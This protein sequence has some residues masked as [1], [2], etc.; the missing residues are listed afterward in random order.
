MRGSYI[1]TGCFLD[2]DTLLRAV[3]PIRQSPLV[4][5]IEAPHVTS[6]FRPKWV[7]R[8]LFGSQME[9]ALIGYGNDGN[10]EGVL[11]ELRQADAAVRDLFEQIPVPHITLAVSETGKPVD[12]KNLRFTPIQTIVLTGTYGGY[13]PNGR[14]Q[15]TP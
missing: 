14:V 3:A 8:A 15:L 13:L 6:A 10:N 1:Y 4:R 9:L 2:R 7:D 12:T 11:V 5:A